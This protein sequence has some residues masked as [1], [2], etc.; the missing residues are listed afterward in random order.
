MEMKRHGFSFRLEF[1]QRLLGLFLFYVWVAEDWKRSG[2]QDS[3]PGKLKGKGTA[4]LSKTSVLS[5]QST[6]STSPSSSVIHHPIVVVW[7]S[8]ILITM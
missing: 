8:L 7:I 6:H 3:A 5:V 1:A 2:Q 4:E